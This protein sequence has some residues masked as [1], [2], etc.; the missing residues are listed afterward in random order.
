MIKKPAGQD[1]L[2]AFFENAIK[3]NTLAHAYIIEGD[4]GSGK[5]TLAAYFAALAACENGTGCG[6]C[7]QCLQTKANTNGDIITVSAE[8]KASIGVEKVRV[9]TDTLSLRTIHGGRRT[10][11]IEDAHLLTSQA[12]NALLKIIEEPPKGTV[13]LILCQRASKMLPTIVSRAQ[14]LKLAPLS[15]DV[16]KSIV[17]SCSDFEYAYCGGNPGKLIKLSRDLDFKSFRDGAADV[18]LKFFTGGDD[19]LYD[20]VDFFELHKER[21]EDLFSI[22][23][24]ILRDVLYK[25]MF[26]SKYII[27]ADKPSV[28]D[29]ICASFDRRGAAKALGIVL[30]C[31][32]GFGKYANYSLAITDMLI[33]C[34]KAVKTSKNQ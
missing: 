2:T 21:K 13:F 24:L 28:I 6:Q 10:V 12:Q 9:I 8:G 34:K 26:L 33:R 7:A 25:K 11:I 23:T 27:N 22:F 1:K 3:N 29:G 19:A 16:L 4:E 15:K 30:S 31:E 14:I 18:I 32:G 20:A 5:K 17:P